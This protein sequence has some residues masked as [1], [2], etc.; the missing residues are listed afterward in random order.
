MKDPNIIAEGI[1]RSIGCKGKWNVN[2]KKAVEAIVYALSHPTT[3]TSSRTEMNPV[4]E[5]LFN[6]L[7][8]AKK[9]LESLKS[10]TTKISDNGWDVDKFEC[11]LELN[12]NFLPLNFYLST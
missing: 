9:E 7:E 10:L 5:K 6:E 3:N 12:L 11:T 4:E 2:K 8:T 1:L